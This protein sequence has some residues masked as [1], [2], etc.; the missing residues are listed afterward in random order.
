MLVA[1]GENEHALVPAGDEVAVV[2]TG[3]I[4]VLD[5]PQKVI[6]RLATAQ[7]GLTR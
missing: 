3:G 4:L 7:R 1:D 2:R 6:D 5:G